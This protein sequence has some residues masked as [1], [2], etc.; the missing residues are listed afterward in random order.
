MWPP[1]ELLVLVRNRQYIVLTNQ[2][3][4]ITR[5]ATRFHIL[6]LTRNHILKY[7]N[8]FFLLQSTYLKQQTPC[9]QFI[10]TKKIRLLNNWKG[11]ALRRLWSAYLR[12]EDVD[13]N[14][15]Q[16]N[17]VPRLLR[18]FALKTHIRRKT[19][20]R[21]RHLYKILQVQDNEI[22]NKKNCSYYWSVVQKSWL[23]F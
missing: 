10:F 16:L 11:N 18:M 9:P 6:L 2:Q 7:M 23:F 20:F 22:Q 8:Y 19:S 14:F 13:L 12:P 5:K 15:Y 21:S 1:L 17:L 3:N 4:Q